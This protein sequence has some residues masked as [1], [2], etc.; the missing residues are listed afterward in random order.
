M[1]AM[2]PSSWR[3]DL[4]VF[5]TWPVLVSFQPTLWVMALAAYG[6]SG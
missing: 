6:D 5:S 1:P 4:A 3:S 2:Q